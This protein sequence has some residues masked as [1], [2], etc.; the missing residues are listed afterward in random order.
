MI[1]AYKAVFTELL[2]FFSHKIL[3][4]IKNMKHYIILYKK[5]TDHNAIKEK[6]LKSESKT[7]EH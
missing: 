7:N 3:I 2:Y 5:N 1:N 4:F 6:L